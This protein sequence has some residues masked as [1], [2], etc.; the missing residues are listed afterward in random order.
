MDS[1]A[2]RDSVYQD[3]KGEGMA[4]TLQ[5]VAPGTYDPDTG[6]VTNTASSHV[7]YGIVTDYKLSDIDGTLIKSNDK[8]V[9]LAATATMPEPCADDQLLIG[10][11]TW[12]VISCNPV[13]PVGVPILFKVQVRK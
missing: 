5:H 6:S 9:F 13:A 11:V 4:I 3:L 12:Q 10:A 2:E 1:A 8:Q 7:S